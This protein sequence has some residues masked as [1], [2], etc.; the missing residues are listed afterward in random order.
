MVVEVT[1]MTLHWMKLLRVKPTSKEKMN[2]MKTLCGNRGAVMLDKEKHFI[3][4]L[5]YKVMQNM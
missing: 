5:D 4:F 3:M 1:M 2:A